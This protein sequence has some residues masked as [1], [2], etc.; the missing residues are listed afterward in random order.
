MPSSAKVP[1]VRLVRVVEEECRQLLLQAG[2]H[3]TRVVQTASP[4][5][6]VE[7]RRA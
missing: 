7:A 6:V 2:W 4:L 1:P 3:M 5:S